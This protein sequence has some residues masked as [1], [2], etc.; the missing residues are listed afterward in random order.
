MSWR[1]SLVRLRC[2][3]LEVSGAVSALG[4]EFVDGEAIRASYICFPQGRWELVNACLRGR[5]ERES[6]MHVTGL[7]VCSP[8]TLFSRKQK[9]RKLSAAGLL[10]LAFSAGMAGAVWQ[11]AIA[12]RS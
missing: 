3:L 2:A 12:W 1:L 10:A 6:S 7:F 11:Q 9:G 8:A 4:F 5:N